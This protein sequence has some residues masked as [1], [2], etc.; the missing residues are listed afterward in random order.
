MFSVDRFSGVKDLCGIR[1]ANNLDKLADK[2]VRHQQT[3]PRDR[4]PYTEVFGGDAQVTVERQ[5]A[6]AG[7]SCALN[8]GDGWDWNMGQPMKYS[9]DVDGSLPTFEPI[10]LGQIE[11]RTK[12]RTCAANDH[13]ADFIIALN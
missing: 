3:D 2:V 7:Q 1:G 12:A 10:G 11:A 13:G 5:F 9:L 8:R 6:P 4:H